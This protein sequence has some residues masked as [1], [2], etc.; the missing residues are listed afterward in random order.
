M[1]KITIHQPAYIHEKGR[2]PNN[3][4]VIFP[5]VPSDGDRLFM[6]C[7]GVGGQDKGEVAAE[8]VCTAFST[9]MNQNPEGSI[10]KSFLESGLRFVEL[11]MKNHVQQYPTTGNM[12]STMTLLYFSNTGNTLHLAWVG[13]SRIYHIRRGCILY[14]TKDHSQVQSL[15]DMGEITEEEAKQHP[16]KNVLLRAVNGHTPTRMDYKVITNIVSNDFLMLCSDGI[17]ETLTE[18]QIQQWFLSHYTTKEIRKYIWE[19][20]AGRTRDNFSMILLKV[21]DI[22]LIHN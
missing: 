1:K 19:N 9:Y 15:M 21:K 20:A 6:V 4:D 10:N 13:D 2:R 3:E 8:I 12:A 22:P 5:R 7:D 17:L 16:K 14:R 11:Q 18:S